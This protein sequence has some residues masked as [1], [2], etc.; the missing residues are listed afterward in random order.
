M[1]NAPR[2]CWIGSALLAAASLPGCFLDDP[3]YV[4]P[5]ADANVRFMTFNAG[6]PDD[7]EPNYPLRLRDQV[8]EDFVAEAIE[9][10]RPDVIALQEVL[11]P[12]TCAAFEETDESRTCYEHERREP[13]ARRLLGD[14][15]SIVC[16]MRQ[17]VECIGVHVDFGTIAGLEPGAMELFGAQTPELPAPSC[18]YAA[19]GCDQNL[20]D[21]E[22]TIS[23]VD[24][25]SHE[26][27]PLRVVHLHPNASGFTGEGIFYL[28]NTCRT[29]Q[30]EQAFALAGDDVPALMLGDWNFD[31]DNTVLY[32]PEAGVWQDHVGADRRF[33]DHGQRDPVGRRIATVGDDPAG[34][35]LDHVISDFADG[36]CQVIR[37]PRFDDHFDF[38]QLAPGGAYTGRIDHH[39][40]LCD[41]RWR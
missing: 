30:T 13:A 27:G 40:V 3:F 7:A 39:P 1:E 12:H 28:G 11:P 4:E 15:Y 25:E 21:A 38:E 14:D 23:A 2:A 16:D 41:L 8:Y 29:L 31:P 10:W 22:S 35:A 17:Q 26:F 24:V 32:G 19:G 36:T 6:N 18:N 33:A 5:P 9:S 20:C 34:V 37:A